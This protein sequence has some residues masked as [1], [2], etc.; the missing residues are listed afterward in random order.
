[1]VFVVGGL[2]TNILPTNEATLPTF[3]YNPSSNTRKYYPRNVSIL[4]N[5]EYF[6]PRKLPATHLETSIWLRMGGVFFFRQCTTSTGIF[7]RLQN[8]IY[9]LLLYITI[10][11]LRLPYVHVKCY[12]SSQRL[13]LDFT[14]VITQIMMPRSYTVITV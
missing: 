9:T 3:T 10:S 2:T 12:H 5:H 13:G 7:S 4:L 8:Y 1:M 11:F 14:L 6:V